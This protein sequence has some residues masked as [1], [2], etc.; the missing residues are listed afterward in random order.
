MATIIAK[1][2]PAL[3]YTPPKLFLVNDVSTATAHPYKTENIGQL[4]AQACYLFYTDAPKP[5]KCFYK[6]KMFYR[7]RKAE[8]NLNTVQKN[9]II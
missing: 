2:K 6:A 4:K 3:A 9:D 7:L 8:Q 5:P 1:I